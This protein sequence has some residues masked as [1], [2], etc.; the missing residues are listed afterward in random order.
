MSL[1]KFLFSFSYCQGEGRELDGVEGHAK[2]IRFL[3]ERRRLLPRQGVMRT[4]IIRV[5]D[6]QGDTPVTDARRQSDVW[7]GTHNMTLAGNLNSMVRI[8]PCFLS[9]LSCVLLTFQ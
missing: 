8:Q 6:N 5:T 4:L 1:T 2:T 7:F 3:S 9:T